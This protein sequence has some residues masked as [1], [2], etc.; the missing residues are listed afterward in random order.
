MVAGRGE[1]GV[2]VCKKRQRRE[3]EEEGLKA[4]DVRVEIE[5][6]RQGEEGRRGGRGV[7]RRVKK[8]GEK[9]S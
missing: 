3:R 6:C 5:G 1:V 4:E 8:E 2:V 7:D 9:G